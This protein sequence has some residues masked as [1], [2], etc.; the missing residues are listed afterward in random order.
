MTTGVGTFSVGVGADAGICSVNVSSWY[1][2]K[3]GASRTGE[4]D[5]DSAMEIA[6]VKSSIGISP[7]V[8]VTCGM[9]LGVLKGLWGLVEDKRSKDVF[10]GYVLDVLMV[11]FLIYTCYVCNMKT[12]FSHRQYLVASIGG[13]TCSVWALVQC[14]EAR[15]WAHLHGTQIAFGELRGTQTLKMHSSFQIW[16]CW[17]LNIG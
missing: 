15:I 11:V 5:P 9:L 4:L 1:W 2:C 16:F 14:P 13:G 12:A 10:R 3:E 6:Q 8:W 7:L 17:N